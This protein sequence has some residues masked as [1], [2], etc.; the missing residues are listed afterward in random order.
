MDE[1]VIVTES[2]RTRL[3][4]KP[5][6]RLPSFLTCLCRMAHCS[7]RSHG[8]ARVAAN[9]RRRRRMGSAMPSDESI[10]R[11]W[12]QS[13]RVTGVL[14]CVWFA[15]S[16][17]VPYFARELSMSVFGWPFSFWVGAQG[18]LI[19]YVLLVGVYARWMNRIDVEHDLAEVD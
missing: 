8:G 7:D 13:Q 18:A 17:G 12:H 10:R 1:A 5:C 3:H 14:L 16:F 19:V 15:V 6:R 9:A 2:V 11:R 4:N